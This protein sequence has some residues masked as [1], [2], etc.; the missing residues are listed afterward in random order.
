MRA[1]RADGK[2]LRAATD[3]ENRFLAYVAQ[4]HSVAEIGELD[5]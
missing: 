1:D 3:E 4:E 5:P 2:Y